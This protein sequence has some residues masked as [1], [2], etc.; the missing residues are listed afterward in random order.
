MEKD[1]IDT[2]MGSD[3][4]KT[5]SDDGETVGS[6]VGDTVE[7]ET[8]ETDGT[9]EGSVDEELNT[10]VE[11]DV[12]DNDSDGVSL[13]DEESSV[14]VGATEDNKDT[15]EKT[16]VII[17]TGQTQEIEECEETSSVYV[18]RTGLRTK[19]PVSYDH[20]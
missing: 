15:E 19:R 11:V 20:R 7:K 3:T 10:S 1:S 16:N 12:G 5:R 17:D 13:E 2:E 14:P 6:I 18:R 4:K 9:S 8:E